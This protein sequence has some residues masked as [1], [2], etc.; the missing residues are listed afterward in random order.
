MQLRQGSSAELRGTRRGVT[1]ATSRQ[2]LQKS[3]T[4]QGMQ[5]QRQ[6]GVL[7]GRRNCTASVPN[8]PPTSRHLKAGSAARAVRVCFNKLTRYNTATVKSSSPPIGPQCR[9]S[10]LA[11]RYR[12]GRRSVT[13][14][15]ESQTQS[16][17]A[18]PECIEC[19]HI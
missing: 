6:P 8:L 18:K 9:L 1:S 11:Y 7:C 10:G 17:Q 2:Q 5:G 4:V 16:P 12:I 13:K 14:N 19:T 15:E 3:S